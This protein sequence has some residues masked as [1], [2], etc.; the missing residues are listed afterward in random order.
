M[1]SSVTSLKSRREPMTMHL[2][3]AVDLAPDIRVRRAGIR[4]AMDVV[5]CKAPGAADFGGRAAT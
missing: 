3:I 4:N 5:R 1:Q 2:H